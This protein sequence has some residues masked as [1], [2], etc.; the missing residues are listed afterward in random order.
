MSD[1]PKTI[2]DLSGIRCDTCKDHREGEA[3]LA[4]GQKGIEAWWKE[5]TTKGCAKIVFETP[6]R[7]YE[8]ER[9][10]GRA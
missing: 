7:D 3:L 10:V 2:P 8:F 5:H 1:W 9:K 6:R 4:L